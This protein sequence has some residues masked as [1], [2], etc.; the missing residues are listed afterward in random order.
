MQRLLRETKFP[1]LFNEDSKGNRR[2]WRIRVEQV[3]PSKCLIISSYGLVE[4]AIQEATQEVTEGKNIGRSN[5]TTCYQQALLQAKS[6]WN[7]KRDQNYSEAGEV[8]KVLLPMLAQQYEKRKGKIAWPV[9]VQRKYNGVRCLAH[10]I[11]D[12]TIVFTSRKGKIYENLS[13]VGESLLKCLEVGEVFD[14]EVYNHDLSLQE[15]L[16]RVKNV[17]GSGKKKQR[18]EER[19]TL[20]EMRCRDLK[21]KKN[22]KSDSG[23]FADSPYNDAEDLQFHVYDVVSAAAYT[24]RLERLR[25]ALKNADSSKIVLAQTAVAKSPDEVKHYHDEFVAEGF[26]GIMVRCPETPYVCDYR[27]AG[28]LKYKEFV[29]DEFLIIGGKSGT[30]KDAETVIFRVVTADGKPFDVRPKGSWKL[31]NHYW[32]NLDDY[33]GKMLTVRYQE[34]TDDGIPRFGVGIAIAISEDR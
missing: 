31:R 1:E 5:E 34:L 4:G 30:G 26:E 24:Q 15:I 21:A 17:K 9:F 13:H 6:T 11:S 25:Q 20:Q 32:V 8:R 28:L 7:K 22:N 14:G 27:S 3:S 12:D 23:F 16:S 10:R 29:D 18:A 19:L 2:V 33:I